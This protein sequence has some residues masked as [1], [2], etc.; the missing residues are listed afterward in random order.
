MPNPKTNY[1]RATPTKEGECKCGLLTP[2]LTEVEKVKDGH[3]VAWWPLA[4]EPPIYKRSIEK[5][6]CFA[7]TPG[8]AV[9]GSAT[10]ESGFKGGERCICKTT[11]KPDVD[12]SE[13]MHG[14]FAALQEVRYYRPVHAE[15]VGTFNIDKKLVKKIGKAYNPKRAELA[16]YDEK[17][18]PIFE[19][20]GGES[21]P[22]ED[23]IIHI[24]D[25]INKKFGIPTKR[26][27][28]DLG[29]YLKKLGYKE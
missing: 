18:K 7:K 26:R 1:Y 2:K 22:D 10:G 27:K 23:A 20:Y 6:S 13:E 4:N 17:G 12:L 14:D 3:V 15:A 8:G 29:A 9:I 19:E 25:E 21:F 28:D 5:V 16:G 11:E 24:R